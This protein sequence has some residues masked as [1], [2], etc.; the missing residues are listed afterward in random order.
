MISTFVCHEESKINSRIVRNKDMPKVCLEQSPEE[1]ATL[2]KNAKSLAKDSLGHKEKSEPT[3]E[4]MPCPSLD[5]NAVGLLYFPTFSKLVE[6]AEWEYKRTLGPLK[7]R[8]VVYLGNL[9]MA[10]SLEII[11]S[12]NS[13]SIKRKDGTIIAQIFT[14]RYLK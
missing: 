5:F 13:A 10:A 9:D 3:L 4:I 8:D 11:V 2:A 1:L 6:L 7:R 12:G 14:D